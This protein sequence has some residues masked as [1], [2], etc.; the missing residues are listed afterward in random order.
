MD[1]TGYQLGQTDRVAWR[2]V[3]FLLVDSTICVISARERPGDPGTVELRNV[4]VIRPPN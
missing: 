4:L 2:A 1:A 3:T